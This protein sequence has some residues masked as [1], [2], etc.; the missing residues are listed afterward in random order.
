MEIF[1]KEVHGLSW[2]DVVG[3][4]L[5]TTILLGWTVFLM[6]QYVFVLIFLVVLQWAWNA[7]RPI[8]VTV[9]KSGILML[10][11]QNGWHYKVE[12]SDIECLERGSNFP[13]GDWGLTWTPGFHRLAFSYS[14]PRNVRMRW[15]RGVRVR[16]KGTWKVFP[17]TD[18]RAFTEALS[19]AGFT[20]S[21]RA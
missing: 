21:M 14:K 13:L 4:L 20:G 2:R 1:F 18:F 12:F 11:R 3:S 5:G 8:V 15:W 10:D 19:K 7:R 9:V 17:V 16:S 6:W